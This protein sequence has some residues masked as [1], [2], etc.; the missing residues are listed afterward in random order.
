MEGEWRTPELEAWV[1]RKIAEQDLAI[2]AI[3]N[4]MIEW[5]HEQDGFRQSTSGCEISS[6]E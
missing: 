5:N 2:F 4:A 3:F 1:D 6:T